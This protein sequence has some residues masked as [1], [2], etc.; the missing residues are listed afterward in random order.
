[1]WAQKTGFPLMLGGLRLVHA[2]AV[3][4]YDSHSLA[5]LQGL[6]ADAR[7]SLQEGQAHGHVSYAEH[8]AS[9][10]A[11]QFPRALEESNELESE[12]PGAALRSQASA[13]QRGRVG[14]MGFRPAGRPALL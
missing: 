4:R 1:M 10:T 3:E 8:A 14:C 7:R 12:F 13:F 2:S 11:P 5:L 6:Q 9:S